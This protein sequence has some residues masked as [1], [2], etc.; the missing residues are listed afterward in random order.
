MLRL[1]ALLG[2]LIIG[3]SARADIIISNYTDVTNDRFSNDGAFFLSTFDLSGVGQTVGGGRWATAI[4]RNV[5]IGA[6]H[7]TPGGVVEF[8]PDNDP[9]STPVQRNLLAGQQIPGTDLVLV[10]LNEDLPS[11]ITHYQF[12]QEAIAGTLPGAMPPFPVDPAGIYQDA[13]AI[14]A[15]LSPAVHPETRDQ[16]FGANRITGYSENVP[17][18]NSDHDSLLLEFDP[19]AHADA[20]MFEAFLQGGDSGAPAFVENGGQLR[21]V[22]T[23]SFV[24]GDGDFTNPGQGSGIN[25]T[26]NQA[27]FINDFIALHASVPEPS[28]FGFLFLFST[29]LTRRRARAV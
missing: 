16:A 2:I 9:S 29:C 8:Y 17:T 18:G 23:N 12:A 24:Y 10:P 26:G 14:M 5:V 6:F 21:L 25:Y 28:S 27:A 1:A 7:S 20:Q 15:G 11:S 22:G 13:I 19:M 3:P 4:S